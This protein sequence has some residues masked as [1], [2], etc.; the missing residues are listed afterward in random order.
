MLKPASSLSSDTMTVAAVIGDSAARFPGV[1]A[2]FLVLGGV[3][4]TSCSILPPLSSLMLE[5]SVAAAGCVWPIALLISVWAAE[6]FVA[7]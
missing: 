5:L 1:A 7:L 2:V 6:V 3:D 4:G